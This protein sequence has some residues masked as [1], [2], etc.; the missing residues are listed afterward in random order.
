VS[1][2]A[3]LERL[4]LSLGPA[5]EVLGPAEAKEIRAAAA[6][7][8]LARYDDGVGRHQG[9]GDDVGG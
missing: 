6:R 9:D 2:Q 4:L 5:A 3:F 7:R 1:G 8:V